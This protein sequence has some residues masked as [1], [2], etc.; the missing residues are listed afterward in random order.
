MWLKKVPGLSVGKRL[1]ISLSSLPRIPLSTRLFSV[2]VAVLLEHF[3]TFEF[4]QAIKVLPFPG[5][6]FS[7]L[8]ILSNIM[9]S[10]YDLVMV[11][12]ITLRQKLKQLH[13]SSFQ[14]T[15]APGIG[16]S[17]NGLSRTEAYRTTYPVAEKEIT[18]M[19]DASV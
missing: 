12:S 8:I 14:L 10:R 4:N 9:S 18:H 19:K 13:H 11:G 6:S 3:Q 1:P 2:I 15:L 7:C 17:M 5:F 16:N